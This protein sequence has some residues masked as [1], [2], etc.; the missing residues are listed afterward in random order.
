MATKLVGHI[1]MPLSIGCL[2]L[3]SFDMQ[4]KYS[5]AGFNGCQFES[6]RFLVS[7]FVLLHTV[8]LIKAWEK[9]TISN[10]SLHSIF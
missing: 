9:M 1:A 4:T 6:S 10:Y 3:G 7:H 2:I 8:P 5:G